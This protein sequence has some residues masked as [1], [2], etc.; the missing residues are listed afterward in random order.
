MNRKTIYE[1]WK[2]T[3][4]PWEAFVKPAL[5]DN[6]EADPND[7][8]DESSP[9]R[10]AM[11][12]WARIDTSWLPDE[13]LAVIIDLPGKSAVMMGLALGRRGLRP[14]MSI[15]ANSEGAEVVDMEAV[16]ELIRDGARFRSSFPSGPG[17]LP[18]FILDSRR[19]GDR[20][21]LPG[22]FDN[23]WILFRSD[24]PSVKRLREEGVSGVVV[25]QEGNEPLGDL[26]AVI[27]AYEKGGIEVVIHD[28]DE[29]GPLEP[30]RINEPAWF[31]SVFVSLRRRLAFSRRWNGS[32]GRRVPI[33]PPPSHG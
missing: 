27:L 15:N 31:M 11:P 14:V 23:R 22:S 13:R 1:V 5:F 7:F 4:H 29:P 24:L 30:A 8:A 28:V 18:A 6:M 9:Y 20:D 3:G 32:F 17:I 33:L 19:G 26:Q 16:V 2:G 25:V 21:P 10:S 12:P